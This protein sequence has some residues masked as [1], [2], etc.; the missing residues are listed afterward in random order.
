M[1]VHWKPRENFITFHCRKPH[2]LANNYWPVAKFRKMAIF[3][4]FQ[5]IVVS[6]I[7]CLQAIKFNPILD[8][9][10]QDAIF[11]DKTAQVSLPGMNNEVLYL[12]NFLVVFSLCS[13][14]PFLIN[15]CIRHGKISKKRQKLNRKEQDNGWDRFFCRKCTCNNDT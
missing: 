8:R 11:F 12:E 1:Y 10:H 15:V 9:Y 6:R 5:N 3:T 13:F 14:Q 7:L 2:Q 4:T